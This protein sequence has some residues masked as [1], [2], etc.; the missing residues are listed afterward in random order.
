MLGLRPIV[1]CILVERTFAAKSSLHNKSHFPPLPLYLFYI[2]SLKIHFV[3]ETMRVF[4]LQR[5]ACTQPTIKSQHIASHVVAHAVI[6]VTLRIK[7][8][9]IISHISLQTYGTPV[10]KTNNQINATTHVGAYPCLK[11]SLLSLL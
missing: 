7:P 9:I 11:T 1:I 3:S 10:A 8:Y 5:S 4:H 2:C 6:H